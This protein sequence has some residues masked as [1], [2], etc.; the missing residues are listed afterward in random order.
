MEWSRKGKCWMCRSKV[1]STQ[2]GNAGSAPRAGPC[3]RQRK[4]RM[5][6]AVQRPSRIRDRSM[7]ITTLRSTCKKEMEKAEDDRSLVQR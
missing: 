7:R 1:R 6:P 2:E 4:K 5:T 3:S